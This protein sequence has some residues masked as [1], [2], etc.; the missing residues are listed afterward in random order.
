MIVYIHGFNSS[1]QSYKAR[2]LG[3]RIASLGRSADYVCPSLPDRPAVAMAML[4]GVLRDCD[5]ARPTL[6][7]AFSVG[8]VVALDPPVD[9]VLVRYINRLSD[10]LFVLARTAN[11]RAGVTE[12]PFLKVCPRVTSPRAAFAALPS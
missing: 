6:V 4:K 9:P 5:P 7:V 2:L 10:L 3:E 12:T 11:Q 1:A 8:A